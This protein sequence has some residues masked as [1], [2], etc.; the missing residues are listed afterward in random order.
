M[1]V[2]Y[3]IIPECYTDTNLIETIAPPLN[4]KGYNHQMGCN[5]VSSK[6]RF[7]LKNS[8]SDVEE[9]RKLLIK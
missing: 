1:N 3:C 9:L 7:N 2:D 8:F 6:M 4:K 5:K